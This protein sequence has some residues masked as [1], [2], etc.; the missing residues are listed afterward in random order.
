M[1][2]IAICIPNYN[3]ANYLSTM[4]LQS[5]VDYWVMDNASTD[6]SVAICIKRGINVITN[7][8]TVDRVENWLRCIAWFEKSDYEW[9]KWLFVGDYLVDDASRILQT[10]I[11]GRG[12]ASMIVFNYDIDYGD[13]YVR[14]WEGLSPNEALQG[15]E[16]IRELLLH[17]NIFGSPIGIMLH[18]GHY[19]IE[20]MRH[21]FIWAADEY[22][23]YRIS[24]QGKVYFVPQSIGIF[25]AK[26][27]KH[28]QELNSSLNSQLE[29][30]EILRLLYLNY[31]HC[32]SKDEVNKIF[33][34]KMLSLL[35]NVSSKYKWLLRLYR[36]L[37]WEK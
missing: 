2:E 28:F 36:K 8:K 21:G 7:S 25:V 24:E 14:R 13:G 18:K 5:G 15:D 27:R 33:E 9:L 23:N 4:D 6:D 17:G 37:T 16:T 30:L 31:P 32:I 26:S 12:D 1:S 29:E 11:M 22:M 35:I 19:D 3:G 34:R 10:A 20:R